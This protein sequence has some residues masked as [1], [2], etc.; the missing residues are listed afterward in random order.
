MRFALLLLAAALACSG[1]DPGETVRAILDASP[2]AKQCFW[3]IRVQDAESGQVL[4]SMNDDKFFVPASNT[5]LFTTSLALRRFGPDHKFRTRVAAPEKPDANGRITEL[6]LIGGGDPNL[7]SRIL[8][9][10]K[11]ERNPDAL[12]ALRSLADKVVAAG[13]KVID[14][15]V[16][17]DDRAYVWE[18]FPSGWGLQDPVYEYGAPVS[19]LTLNDSALEV[20]IFAGAEPGAPASLAFS[21]T[22]EYFTVVNRT[23]TVESGNHRISFERIPGSRELIVTG[24]VVQNKTVEPELIAVDDPALFAATAFRQLLEQRG[25]RINGSTRAAHRFEGDDT[26][27]FDGVELG[28][29]ESAPL[30]QILQVVNKVSQNLHT[31][32]LLR[33]IAAAK[34]GIGT[35]RAGLAEIAA[36]LKEIGVEEGQWNFSDASG[37]SR[38]G[39]VTPTTVSKVLAA[40]YPTPLRDVWME[41]LPVGGY[42]GTLEKRFDKAEPARRIRA[43]T[44][45]LS[46]VAALSGYVQ[47]P[48]GK[49]YIFSML[50]NNFNVEP[51]RIRGVMDKVALALLD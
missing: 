32:M 49:T 43:K 34:H 51:K 24:A 27:A 46:H 11:D 40:M 18:P 35:R 7:S 33:E 45:S 13:V 42:D 31:E 29:H 20:N 23:H 47:R 9:Y 14:G 48:D 3:G 10:N 21:P 1:A 30:S 37:L 16:V 50:V 41:T 17:G 22:V 26:P 28:A 4:V 39:L 5:K 25:I 44:G 8:P 15:D 36:F 2:D 38:L 19:A 12:G 6:R